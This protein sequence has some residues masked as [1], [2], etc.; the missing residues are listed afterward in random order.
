[1]RVLGIEFNNDE[2]AGDFR[3]TG[4]YEGIKISCKLLSSPVQAVTFESFL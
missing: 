1:M 3:V 4:K 2:A